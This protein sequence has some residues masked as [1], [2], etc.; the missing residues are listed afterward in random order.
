MDSGIIRNYR[1]QN[2]SPI[3]FDFGK[4]R[5]KIYARAVDPYPTHD[6]EFSHIFLEVIPA[7]GPFPNNKAGWGLTLHFVASKSGGAEQTGFRQFFWSANKN[8]TMHLANDLSKRCGCKLEIHEQT[9][10]PTAPIK[11]IKWRFWFTLM[12]LS[13]IM[14]I[15][16]CFLLK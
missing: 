12:A 9:L 1:D 14:I 3:I 10:V 15:A 5:V 7:Q 11:T 16:A 6:L 4:G 13:L 2:N 8:E